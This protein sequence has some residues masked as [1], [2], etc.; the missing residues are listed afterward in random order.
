MRRR[1]AVGVV[2]VTLFSLLAGGAAASG[3]E[4]EAAEPPQ[5]VDVGPIDALLHNQAVTNASA[6]AHDTGRGCLTYTPVAPGK[7]NSSVWVS[8][9]DVTWS[10]GAHGTLPGWTWLVNPWDVYCPYPNYDEK[11]STLGVSPAKGGTVLLDEAFLLGAVSH[12][13]NRVLHDNGMTFENSWFFKGDFSFRFRD[14]DTTITF[15]W[16]FNE[17]NDSSGPLCAAGPTF[18][19]CPDVVKFLRGGEG[20][21]SVSVD[22]MEYRLVV[23]HIE[24]LGV[25]ANRDRI[26]QKPCPV[27]PGGQRST[28]F[29]TEEERTT[30]GC[31][32]ARLVPERPLIVK[33]AVVG[34]NAPAETFSFTATSTRDASPWRANDGKFSLKADES[35]KPGGILSDEKLTITESALGD[36][37]WRLSGVQCVDGLGAPLGG[38]TVD[39]ASRTLTLDSVPVATSPEEAPITCTF[40]NT[41]GND[42]SLTLVK[43]VK[44]G[45]AEP[46]AWTL[47]ATL[48]GAEAL[49]G[50]SG[51]SGS[52]KPGDYVLAET[53]GPGGYL[54]DGWSCVSNSGAAPTMVAPDQVRLAARSDVTCTVTNVYTTGSFTVDK[55]LDLGVGVQHPVEFIDAAATFPMSYVCTL[56]DGTSESGSL[57]AEIGKPVMSPAFPVGTECELTEDEA[58]KLPE[59]TDQGYSWADVVFTVDGEPAS[60]VDGRSVRFVI[61][62][63]EPGGTTTVAIGV[64]NSVRAEDFTVH[65]VDEEGALLD[66]ASFRV[67]RDDRGTPVCDL[68]AMDTPAQGVFTLA[69]LKPGVYW[70][71]ERAAPSGY[72]ALSDPVKVT[73]A[74]DGSVSVDDQSANGLV[75]VEGRVIVVQNR[76]T[77]LE[78]LKVSG[79]ADGEGVAL[80]GASFLV[81]PLE[82]TNVAAG[83][84]PVPGVTYR[85]NPD[86]LQVYT[87]LLAE[88]PD[89]NVKIVED[90]SVGTGLVIVEGLRTTVRYGLVEMV[91][92]GGHALLAEP[93]PFTISPD[94]SAELIWSL[95]HP[96]ATTSGNRIVI[97][98][99]KTVDLP[100]AGADEPWSYLAVIGGL[101][102]AA[103]LTVRARRGYRRN[104][105]PSIG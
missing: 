4:A 68:P 74:G 64:V 75:T 7:P 5:K 48:A 16:L 81:F 42:A 88:H 59:F 60:E 17:T 99:Y 86:D 58:D 34:T 39:L 2:A 50:L 55:S 91:A 76:P 66:G 45:D 93:V 40:T 28:S 54:S 98:D 97:A 52:V 87:A 3:A 95:I 35:T 62:G 90:D 84:A 20:S 82:Q 25:D 31:V 70:L 36:A 92:P 41:Y 65:K 83:A 71:E 9:P 89:W 53:G 49:S 23:S 51:T 19:K 21:P 33:K 57:S 22:G 80:D 61:D 10:R 38:A 47:S 18:D 37:S 8:E 69:A 104:E 44:G 1:T 63:S 15:P 101:V 29:T 24:R 11:Q 78:I 100:F 79:G 13:N 32:Y 105:Q 67:C 94:R 85:V 27:A 77:P 26:E 72:T 12:V 96:E 103:A 6:T 14:L 102:I 43:K 46:S 30:K 73:V 56:P